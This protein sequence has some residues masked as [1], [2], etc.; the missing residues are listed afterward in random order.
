MCFSF[1]ILGL[2]EAFFS[3]SLHFVAFH[4]MVRI[5]D[6]E[7]HLEE[8]TA[9]LVMAVLCSINKGRKFE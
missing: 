8:V 4:L 9:F 7:E 6:K 3:K 1:L 5:T 2:P